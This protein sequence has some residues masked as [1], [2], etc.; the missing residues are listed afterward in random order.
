MSWARGRRPEAE[1]TSGRVTGGEP[2]VTEA[3]EHGSSSS[4]ADAV[5][6]AAADESRGGGGGWARNRGPG[7]RAAQSVSSLSKQSSDALGDA[8]SLT[9]RERQHNGDAAGSQH[10][11]GRDGV[12]S[13]AVLADKGLRRR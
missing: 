6:D 4:R 2:I 8:T 5:R 7:W 12:A 1:W 9:R 11:P 3:V 13:Q 10:E